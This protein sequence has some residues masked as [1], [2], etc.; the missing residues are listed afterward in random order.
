MNTCTVVDCITKH[1]AKSFCEYHYRQWQKKYQLRRCAID[2]CDKVVVSRKGWCQN[3][4]AKWKRYG[5]PLGGYSIE[6][7]SMAHT[8]EY[9]IWN[10]IKTRCNNPNADSYKYYGA[11][12][13]KM[14]KEWA[15]SFAQFVNDMGLSPSPL[16]SIDRQDNNKGYSKENCM[17]ATNQEQALN[18]RLQTNNTSGYRGITFNKGKNSWRVLLRDKTVGL[19]VY[20]GSYKTPEEA[21]YVRDQ[22]MMQYHEGQTIPLNFEY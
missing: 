5:N 19:K 2:N 14:S 16:H 4:F 22:I 12:G 3:H 10:N 20:F 8:R 7:H 13:I 9:R 18:H 11:R 17:W 21:A 15:D 1:Y 6:R